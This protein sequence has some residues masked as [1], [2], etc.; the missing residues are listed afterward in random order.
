MVPISSSRLFGFR[1]KVRFV[2]VFQQRN[3]PRKSAGKS[4][5]PRQFFAET[6]FGGAELPS[7]T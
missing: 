6:S 4:F 2:P 1:G 7:L 3:V 5:L